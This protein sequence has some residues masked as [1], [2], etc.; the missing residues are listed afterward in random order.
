MPDFINDWCDVPWC[1]HKALY[2]EYTSSIAY[3]MYC[4]RHANGRAPN[5]AHWIEYLGLDMGL[6]LRRDGRF[7][8]TVPS[9]L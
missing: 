7:S 5:L 6:P 9:I 3:R 4:S 2:Y 8:S 1:T